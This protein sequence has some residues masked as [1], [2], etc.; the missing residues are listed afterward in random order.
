[1]SLLE[2][3]AAVSFTILALWSLLTLIRRS[4]GSTIMRGTLGNVRPEQTIHER[5]HV[6]RYPY[7]DGP[8]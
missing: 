8:I 4:P 5:D 1:M 3:A 2:A 6:R 7:D